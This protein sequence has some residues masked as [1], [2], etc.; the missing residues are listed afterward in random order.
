MVAFTSPNQTKASWTSG[1]Q[2]GRGALAGL[3]VEGCRKRVL[4]SPSFRVSIHNKDPTRIHS[5]CM[6]YTIMRDFSRALSLTH[7]HNP[8]PL[9]ALSCNRTHLQLL[10]LALL[11]VAPVA[12]AA[13]AAGGAGA[14]AAGA[15]AGGL[16]PSLDGLVGLW[17]GAAAG[18]W[19]L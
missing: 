3:C 11:H 14:R 5:H 7:R 6:A 16:R 8:L 17:A 18:G 9:P 2:A 1:A 12:H 4:F 13:F 19:G 15:R 10:E